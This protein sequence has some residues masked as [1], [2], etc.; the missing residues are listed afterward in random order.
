MCFNDARKRLVN[1][2]IDADIEEAMMIDD[3]EKFEELPLD[4]PTLELKTLP[5]TLKYAFLDEDKAKLVI[6]LS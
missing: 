1:Q 2:H 6:I 5:L 3:E 4:E